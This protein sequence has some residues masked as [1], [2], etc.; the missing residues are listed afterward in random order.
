MK[1][2]Y[3]KLL[4]KLGED[5]EKIYQYLDS[6]DFFTAPASTRFHGSYEGG[7]AEH[8]YN[9]YVALQKIK[10]DLFRE[11]YSIETLI[12]VSILHDICKCNFYKEST[13]NVKN[14]DTGK[15]EQV[16]YYTI[17]DLI[18][19][20]HGEKS[21]MLANKIIDLTDEEMFAIRFHMGFSEPKEL[22]NALGEAMNKYPLVLALHMADL[23]S[24]YYLEN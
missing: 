19:Y 18:P 10:E 23:Y 5:G 3:K 17:E 13:R 24:T 4:N 1:E 7:L 2:R 6:T 14:E 15:W 8:S 22:Y 12:K 21:V 9:V 16:P 11:R 20:G